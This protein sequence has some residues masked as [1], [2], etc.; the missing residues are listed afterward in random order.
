MFQKCVYWPFVIPFLWIT[1]SYPMHFLNLFFLEIFWGVIYIYWIHILYWLHAL[2]PVCDFFVDGIFYIYSYIYHFCCYM[3]FPTDPFG[4]ISPQP[5]D[6]NISCS[7][8][9]LATNYLSF[10]LSRIVF[11]S[12]PYFKDIITG[13]RVL[14]WLGFFLS[15]L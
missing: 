10:D 3:H 2:F 11:T 1:C 8:V 14:G 13:Y 6:F 7:E 15:A 12:L 9:L 5:K 4:F